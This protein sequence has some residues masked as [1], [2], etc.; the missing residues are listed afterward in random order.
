M[1][2]YHCSTKT[3]S[4]GR[5]DIAALKAAYRSAEKLHDERTG[6]TFDYERRG[7]VLHKEIFAP[8]H[9]PEWAQ[10]RERLWNEAEAAE[11]YKNAV[12]AREIEVSLPWELSEKERLALARAHGRYLSQRYG[13]VVDMAMHAPDGD[14][15]NFHVHYLLT[16]RK[17]EREGFGEKC[18]LELSGK[19]KK[20]L[21]LPTGKQQVKEIRK[22]WADQANRHLERAG[23][24]ERIDH[25]SFK[26]RGLDREATQHMGPGAN[27]MER[28]GAE[29]RIG[30]KNR[31][32]EARN[33]ERAQREE[34]AKV[35]NLAIEREKRRVAEERAAQQDAYRRAA[36]R[37]D[38]VEKTVDRDRQTAEAEQA[39]IDAAIEAEKKRQAE[40]RRAAG[41][42][43]RAAAERAK[44]EEWGNRRLAGLQSSHHAALRALD[45]DLSRRRWPKEEAV[46][47]QYRFSLT[48]NRASIADLEEKLKQKGI[49]GMLY[50]ARHGQKAQEQLEAAR[51]SLENAEM[52]QAEALQTIQR[53]AEAERQQLIDRQAEERRE[54]EQENALA[55]ARRELPEQKAQQQRA[56]PEREQ[57]ASAAAEFARQAPGQ[58][59]P[60]A[61]QTPAQEPANQNQPQQGQGRGQSME[62]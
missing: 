23:R 58:N 30:Q 46:K 17:I 11:R 35:I 15:R 47:N 56:P 16:T 45:D 13:G 5:G 37:K 41:E 27:K 9:A 61:Q 44:V 21:D 7:G 20:E 24:L 33:A 1:A 54:M 4:R 36:G 10:N 12:I 28:D 2:I 18:E 39:N 8:A 14:E 42:A 31:A 51:L 60:Q 59:A 19:K 62:R 40:Q 52:R 43:R 48:Q 55:L 50:R 6:Q 57:N 38:R 25:R 3:F 53:Q 26:D 29:S 22:D 32:I 49:A 34:A